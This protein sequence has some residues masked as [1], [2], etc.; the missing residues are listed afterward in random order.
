MIDIPICGRVECID[1]PAGRA[2]QVIINYTTKQATHLVVT[3]NGRHRVDHLIPVDQVLDTTPDMVRLGC[4]R[5]ELAAMEPFTQTERLR[6]VVRH[7]N[8]RP[9]ADSTY[10]APETEEWIAVK[11]RRVPVGET[12]VG[13]GAPVQ[14]TDGRVGRV[15][16]FLADPENGHIT[17]LVLRE[18]PWWDRKDATIPASE[19]SFVGDGVIRLKL[20]KR[21]VRSLPVVPTR[22]Q[23]RRA[24]RSGHSTSSG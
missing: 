19:I 10:G 21:A 8:E 9:Y 1:G 14:A 12:V 17:H 4:T 5:E 15:Q 20:D 6:V 24:W 7:L 3:E 22:Q 2:T 16:R 18:G 13:H 23:R 11:R